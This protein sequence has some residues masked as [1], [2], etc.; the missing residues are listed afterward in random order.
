MKYAFESHE[1][2]NCWLCPFS[3]VSDFDDNEI[4]C[5][6]MIMNFNVDELP[7]DCPLE[8]VE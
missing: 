1:I 6:L 5:R 7:E 8:L 2:K 3:K 4:F